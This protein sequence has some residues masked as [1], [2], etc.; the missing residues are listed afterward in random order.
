ML[1]MLT[2]G[3]EEVIS[4]VSIACSGKVILFSDDRGPCPPIDLLYVKLKK[5]KK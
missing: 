1:F 2:C 4:Y 5:K 3:Q